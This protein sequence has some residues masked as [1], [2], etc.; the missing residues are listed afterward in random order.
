MP[1]C[2]PLTTSNRMFLACGLGRTQFCSF[3]IFTISATMNTWEKKTRAKNSSF[4][5]EEWELI[6]SFVHRS[7]I[8]G[9]VSQCPSVSRSIRAGML[10][11]V[12]VT[13]GQ[14]SHRLIGRNL[15]QWKTLCIIWWMCWG[16]QRFMGSAAGGR[17]YDTSWLEE[18]WSQWCHLQ[19]SS[20]LQKHPEID[21]CA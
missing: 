2:Y 20:L 17:Y 10:P 11:S 16:P 6:F 13:D 18:L 12:T 15:S 19:G 8:V 4:L 7:G 3:S 21:H 9:E 5:K 1:P 14:P